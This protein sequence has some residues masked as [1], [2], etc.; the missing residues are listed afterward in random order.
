MREIKNDHLVWHI[1]NILVNLFKIDA[2]LNLPTHLLIPPPKEEETDDD[3]PP[4][5]G[6]KDNDVD[7]KNMKQNLS[8]GHGGSEAHQSSSNHSSDFEN[9]R[10]N[11]QMKEEQMDDE[12]P[13]DEQ[14]KGPK[15]QLKRPNQPQ[16]TPK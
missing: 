5:D 13:K 2:K 7:V 3:N 6:A 9:T 1:N 14:I 8:N 16:R 4:G 11:K 15:G 10:Q 12:N